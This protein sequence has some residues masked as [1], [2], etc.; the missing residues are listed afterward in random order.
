MAARCKNVCR[1]KERRT[2]G[3]DLVDLMAKGLETMAK[4]GCRG[5]ADGSTE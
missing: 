1:S 2:F 5:L 3:I 4:D